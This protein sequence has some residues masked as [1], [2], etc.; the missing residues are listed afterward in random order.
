MLHGEHVF[1]GNHWKKNYVITYY[2]YGRKMGFK[3]CWQLKTVKFVNGQCLIKTFSPSE[4]L[5]FLS[6]RLCFLAYA[7]EQ[8]L[9]KSENA[10]QVY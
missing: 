10:S 9:E 7:M 5:I 1:L 2:F 3:N 4:N 8:C 6:V